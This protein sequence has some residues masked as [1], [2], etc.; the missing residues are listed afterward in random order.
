MSDVQAAIL[1][2][3]V[4]AVAGFLA[5]LLVARIPEPEEKAD[6]D[7]SEAERAEG[8]KATYASIAVLPWFALT[9]LLVSGVAGGL[10]GYVVGGSWLLVGLVPL[11]PVGVALAVVDLRTRMLPR[12]VVVPATLV[13][14]ALGVL[15]SATVFD[16]SDLVRGLVGL[17]VGRS[18]YWVL[19]FVRSAGMG[20]GDVRLAALL[21]FPLAYVGWPE[22]AVGMY[23]G[24]LIF[25]VPGALHALVRWDARLLKVHYP[26]GPFM[27]AGALIGLCVGDPVVDY[28]VSR[29]S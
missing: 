11:V 27:I 15:G 2:A 29:Q 8:P 14:L 28:L 16:W 20:F 18:F 4:C 1:A 9:S 19:W 5:P 10:V 23:A 3:V 7:K 21:A 22:F 13:L 17:A 25:G 6:A 26:Y 12:V 24:F